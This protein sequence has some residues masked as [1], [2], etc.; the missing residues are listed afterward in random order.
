MS[1]A[2]I[3]TLRAKF[4]MSQAVLARALGMSKESVSKWER[5]KKKTSGPAQRML[6]ILERQGPEILIV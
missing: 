5:G 1:G 3:K 4:G 2:E 6:R